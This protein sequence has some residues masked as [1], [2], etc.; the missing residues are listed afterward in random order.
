MAKTDK[1]KKDQ[2]IVPQT[3]TYR[4]IIKSYVPKLRFQSVCP[5][6]NH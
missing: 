2:E 4:R 6:C 5:K 1:V 3:F